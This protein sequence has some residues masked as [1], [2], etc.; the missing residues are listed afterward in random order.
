M[1][2]HPLST[3]ETSMA[4]SLEARRRHGIPRYDADIVYPS[5]TADFFS[6]DYLSIGNVPRIRQSFIDTLSRAPSLF[7]STGSRAI[8][9]TTSQHV[10]L[11]DY[12]VDQFDVEKA[13]IFNSGYMCNLT[14]FGYAPQEGDVILYDESIHASIHDGIRIGRARDHAFAFAHNCVSDFEEKLKQILKDYPAIPSGLSTL[15]VVIES[16][17]SMEGDFAPMEEIADLVEKYVPSKSAHIVVDEAHSLGL[18]GPGGKGLLRE[19]GIA[20]RVH[21]VIFPFTKAVNFIGCVMT[22]TP[23]IYQYLSNYGR[24]W[25]FTTSLPHVDLVGIKF[26]FEAVQSEEANQLRKKVQDLSHL[27]V[28]LFLEST[29]DIPKDVMSIVNYESKDVHARGLIAPVFPIRTPEPI[30]LQGYL[31][32]LGYAAKGLVYPGVPKGTERIRVVIHGGNTEDQVRRFVKSLRVWAVQQVAL[33]TP[34][35]PSR[36]AHEGLGSLYKL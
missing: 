26:C 18:Y 19:W 22:T 34:T 2:S 11:E 31:N 23:T 12:F 17:Y 20:K 30:A 15:F 6:N 28:K 3:L 14:F 1:S 5:H 10:E 25:L 29:Y 13:M 16:V 7:G 27:F 8:S 21:T 33:T 4:A 24:S 32:K 36:V 35:A 9:G